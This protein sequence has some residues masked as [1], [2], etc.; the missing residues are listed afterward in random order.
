MLRN[1]DFTIVNGLKPLHVE[2]LAIIVV[3]NFNVKVVRRVPKKV[4]MTLPDDE[5]IAAQRSSD[6]C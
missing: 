4:A 5:K 6:T 3:H 2:Y 1:F